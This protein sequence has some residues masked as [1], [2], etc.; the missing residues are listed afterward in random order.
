ML[1]MTTSILGKYKLINIIII[2]I[3]LANANLN[4]ANALTGGD[5]LEKLSKD[6]RYSY[7]SGVVEGLGYARFVTEKPSTKGSNC[8]HDW[9]FE[10]G[11]S[12][13]KEIKIWLGHHKDKTAGTIIYAMVSKEC[14]K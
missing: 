2:G 14:G 8:I 5:V 4:E 12:R 13:W 10:G 6:E 11:V 3:S 7:I 9:F 1:N